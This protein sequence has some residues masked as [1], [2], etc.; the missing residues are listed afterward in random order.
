MANID[1][2]KAA[3]DKGVFLWEIAS[4]FGFSEPT[5]TR[6]FRVEM[7]ES[8]KAEILSVIEKI[9]KTKKASS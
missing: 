7:P 9:S 6:K 2:R 8:E 4:Y 3:K 1:V 5:L